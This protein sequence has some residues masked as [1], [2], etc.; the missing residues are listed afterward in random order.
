MRQCDRKASW[1]MVLPKVQSQKCRVSE[2]TTRSKVIDRP[3]AWQKGVDRIQRHFGS[4][5]QGDGEGARA[6]KEGHC[7]QKGSAKEKA[8]VGRVGRDRF[9]RRRG[10]QRKRRGGS[11]RGYCCR[12]KAGEGS[13]ESVERETVQAVDAQE[14]FEASSLGEG[15]GEEM[16][17]AY[18][19]FVTTWL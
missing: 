13:R 7:Y 19:T 2:T 10:R 17:R 18:P 14:D 16:L 12:G 5:K 15:K 4:G 8:Q 3:K 11:E 1:R 6:R 9:R